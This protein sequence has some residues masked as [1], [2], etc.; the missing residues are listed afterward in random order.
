[1]RDSPSFLEGQSLFP[2]FLNDRG[3]SLL[4]IFR[5][6]RGNCSF[7]ENGK[8]GLSLC[9]KNAAFHKMKKGKK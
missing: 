4:P 6:R 5:M 2:I 7:H 3:Q 1:M 8:E 9:F